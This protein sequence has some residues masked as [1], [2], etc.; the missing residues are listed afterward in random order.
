MGTPSKRN[1]AKLALR[2]LEKQ[3]A[4]GPGLRGLV[5]VD[6]ETEEEN[7]HVLARF[8]A[9]VRSRAFVGQRVLV[10]IEDI[11]LVTTERP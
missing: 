3:P 11:A 10:D 2:L 6:F 1:R 9:R 4:P 8:T 7:G 5:W